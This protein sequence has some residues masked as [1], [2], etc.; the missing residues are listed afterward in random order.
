MSEPT[1]LDRAA[2][3][4]GSWYKLAKKLGVTHQAVYE[5]KAAGYVPANRALQIEIA[6]GISAREL[7]RPELLEIA[8][9]L[10]S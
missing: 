2:A 3:M 10:S 7:V 6:F 4:A 5:W 8:D 1:A 9:L